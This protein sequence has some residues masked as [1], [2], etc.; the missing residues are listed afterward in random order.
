DPKL[1]VIKREGRQRREFSIDD[2]IP[3]IRDKGII[4]PITVHKDDY[5][6]VAGERRLTA[7]LHLGLTEV[8]VR[9]YENLT[10]LQ[11]R[12][13]E[14]SENVHRE[15]LSWQDQALAAYELHQMYIEE[16]DLKHF[17]SGRDQDTP[18]KWSIQQSAERM[19]LKRVQ[20]MKYVV[21]GEAIAEGDESLAQIDTLSR[22]YS[23]LERRRERGKAEVI[24][25]IMEMATVKPKPRPK[26]VAE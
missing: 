1:I 2:L 14:L 23:A 11:L 7:A 24:Q 17:P 26:P 25:R 8:P 19:G 20:G 9:F 10:P 13:L 18:P 12:E 3:T 22:A 4:N 6:L 5:S 15:D 21:L 16:T